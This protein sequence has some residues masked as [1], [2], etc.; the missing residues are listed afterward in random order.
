MNTRKN[1]EWAADWIARD[2]A[3]GNN[4]LLSDAATRFAIAFVSQD[5]S[6]FDVSRF[7]NRIIS[8]V[9]QYQRAE[10]APVRRRCVV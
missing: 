4:H 8:L 9:T 10:E 5:N 2:E 1:F 6:R 7:Q 3:N